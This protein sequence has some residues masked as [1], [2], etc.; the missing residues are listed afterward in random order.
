MVGSKVILSVLLVPVSKDK[1][2][3]IRGEVGSLKAAEILELPLKIILP[4]ALISPY[5]VEEPL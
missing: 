4:L 5:K 3:L 1:L 2:A